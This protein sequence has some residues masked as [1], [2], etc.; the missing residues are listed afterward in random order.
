MAT[1]EPITVGTSTRVRDVP[2]GEHGINSTWVIWYHNPS[3]NNWDTSSYVKLYEIN[4]LE[5]FFRFQN[6]WKN[7]LPRLDLSMMFMMKKLDNFDEYIYPMWEDKNNQ[8]G[9]CWSFKVNSENINN[10]WINLCL[11]ILSENTGV[12]QQVNDTINGISFSPKRGFCIVKIWNSTTDIQDTNELNEGLD[13]FMSLSECLYKSHIDSIDRDQKKKKKIEDFRNNID[14]NEKRRMNKIRYGKHKNGKHKNGQGNNNSN[15]GQNGHNEHNC[16]PRRKTSRGPPGRQA[17]GP[18]RE[19]QR[20]FNRG[21]GNNGFDIKNRFNT[22]TKFVW[23]KKV[24]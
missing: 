8:P 16:F 6:S 20:G 15:Y 1:L 21:G 14:R 5:D 9:G 17:K 2:N 3:D 4:T 12:S 10:V 24:P 13:T 23:G 7:T 18:G 22:E 11:Y 19:S